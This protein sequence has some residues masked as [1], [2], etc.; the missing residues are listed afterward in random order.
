MRL[1]SIGPL[2][3]SKEFHIRRAELYHLQICQSSENN[4]NKSSLCS[5]NVN[6]SWPDFLPCI[7]FSDTLHR[8][9]SFVIDKITSAK[10]NGDAIRPD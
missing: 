8:C 7:L 3:L 10:I 4:E 6:I 1:S 9:Q 2:F 5:E